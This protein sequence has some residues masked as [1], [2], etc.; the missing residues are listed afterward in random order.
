MLVLSFGVH[1]R[2]LFVHASAKRQSS[3][4]LYTRNSIFHIAESC[5]I[6]VH[7]QCTLVHMKQEI[8]QIW[9]LINCTKCTHTSNAIMK[10]K[11]QDPNNHLMY[12]ENF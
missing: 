2:Y 10:Y 9:I 8:F 4:N 5:I 6:L 1:N 11:N 12:D 3:L 7:V